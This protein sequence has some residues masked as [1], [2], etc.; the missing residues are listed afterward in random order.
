MATIE[1]RLIHLLNESTTPQV[2]HADL[3]PLYALPL[4]SSSDRPLPP[5]EPEAAN[6]YASDGPLFGSANLPSSSLSSDDVTPSYR[7]DDTRWDG[8]PSGTSSHPLRML[9]GEPDVPE[10]SSSSSYSH[11]KILN[12]AAE[13]SDDSYSKK[14]PRNM[15][16]KDD[17]VQL[18]QPMKKQKSAQQSLTMPPIINGLHE[19]PP[20]AALFP[21]IASTSFNESEANQVKML[22][23]FGRAA[24]DNNYVA[25][26]PESDKNAAGKARKRAAKPRRKWSEEETKHLLLGVNRHGVGKWTTILEDPDFTFNE[27]TAG[28]LKDRFRT[29]CPVELRGPSKGSQPNSPPPSSHDPKPKAK[30][31]IHSENILIEEDTPSPQDTTASSPPESSAPP[32]QKKSRAHRK[33]LEDLAELGIH[34]PFKKSLRRERRPFTEQDDREILDGL[35]IYGPAWTKIQ[36]DSRFHLSSRQPTDLRDRVRNKYPT[37]YQRI[38]KGT[39]QAKDDGRGNDT[40][41]PSI[42][43]SIDDSLKRSKASSKTH[44][45]SYGHSKDELHPWPMQM[46]DSANYMHPPHAFEFGEST[47]HFMGGEMD[48]SRLL[49]DDSRL[50]K[51][52][53]RLSAPSH[54]LLDKLS[55]TYAPKPSAGPHK[56]RDCMPLI[57]FIRNRLK[58]A[59]NYRE[60]KAI[61]M[62]RLVKVD[63]KVRTDMTYPAGFMDVITID[64]T[65]ENFRLVYDTKGRFTVHRIQAEEAEYKLGKV[66]RVQLGRGGIPFLVTHDARTIRYPDPAIKVNDTVKIDLSTGKIT[67]FIKF[68]TGAVAMVTGGRNMGRVGVITHRERHDGGFNI[69]HIKDAIDNSFATR[70]S[71]VF[72]IGQDKPWI[73]LPKGKGVKLSIA[74]ERDRRRSAAVVDDCCI[75]AAT[76]RSAGDDDVR[77]RASSPDTFRAVA[78][79]L[80]DD[81]DDDDDEAIRVC[82]PLLLPQLPPLPPFGLP[83]G[84][85]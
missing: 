68:D 30:K 60:T 75:A 12:D 26:S 29:C 79:A 1:P 59:L 17:F 15:T 81:D 32:K 9:L 82:P 64:K 3:P 50:K 4:P 41:E 7:K 43:M 72:V 27:R 23:D 66:K 78:L 40:L 63:A 6:R 76:A 51:H 57:V 33:K 48:I 84:R 56:L 54:W 55:G 71:N 35:E 70:E 47:S 77:P 37:V 16:V 44:R 11:A 28:D 8:R 31:G 14:R 39:F 61:L 36:R 13:T 45:A 21:P 46:L 85:S 53:K 18:P 74:E 24:P 58:Y 52:Q 65:G 10:A 20:H 34:G 80:R 69:V 49:L 22:H 2:Q 25:S 67:D 73:S 5:I 83:P 19:P 42:D 38:E 62:Q